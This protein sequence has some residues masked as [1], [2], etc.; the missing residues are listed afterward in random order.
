MPAARIAGHRAH[1]ALQSQHG[2]AADASV[3]LDVVLPHGRDEAVVLPAE[4]RSE[5]VRRHA[6]AGKA[7]RDEL[8]A[9]GFACLLYTSDAADEL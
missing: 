4:E 2:K 1:A 9:Q 3:E 7:L 8:V 5:I 6:V